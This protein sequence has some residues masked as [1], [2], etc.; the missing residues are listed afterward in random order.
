MRPTRSIAQNERWCIVDKRDLIS[1]HFSND[2]DDLFRF[3]RNTNLPVGYF[4][5]KRLTA[6]Q[7]VVWTCILAGVIAVIWGH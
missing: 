1:S 5:R 3:Q 4:D 6:D 7:L 2:R